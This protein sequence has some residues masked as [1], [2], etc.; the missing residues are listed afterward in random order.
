MKAIAFAASL[1]IAGSAIEPAHAQDGAAEDIKA[2]RAELDALRAKVDGLE[3]ALA[4]KQA[5]APVA[6]AEAKPEPKPAPTPAP[7]QI[8]MR[9]APQFQDKERGYAFKPRG[10]VQFDAGRVGNPGGV[11]PE[12]NLGTRLRARR[13]V[14]GADGSLPAGFAYKA[15]FN[16]SDGNLGYED[17]F[18]TWQPKDSAF[19]V[20][21]GHVFPLAGL[22]ANTSSRVTTMVER[23]QA[24]D[25]F[26]LP[27]R[28]GLS[29]GL[30]DP[31]DGYTLQA[32]VYQNTISSDFADNAWQASVRGTFSHKLGE[33]SR[34]HIGASFQHRRN[35]TDTK[36]ARYR[37]RPFTNITDVR[38]IDTSVLTAG[39]DDILG[40]E[41]AAILGPLHFAAEGH[42]LWVRDY[43][44][45]PDQGGLLYS[46]GPSF[47]TAYGEV[48]YFLTG[49][50]RGYK[51]GKW[52]RVK[53]AKPL[54]K[55]GWGAFQV[56]ARFERVDLTDRFGGGQFID[57]GVQDGY[58]VSASW[59]PI[60]HL[61]FLLQYSRIEVTGG[62][63]AALVVP[64]S[65]RP[66]EQRSFDTD[67]MVLRAQ[68][69]F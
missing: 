34:L 30:V 3:K 41:F 9:A 23:S 65:N 5:A 33:N 58:S 10:F 55:G 31:K 63:N 64:D 8:T 1:A 27:R 54:D 22:D 48:G 20:T 6:V 50:A 47:F 25:A 52:E 16:L 67:A 44:A 53:V 43:L 40:A 12:S 59:Y 35:R 13:I 39:G 61:R 60:D 49:E 21:L 68:F 26:T 37:T 42:K 18:L 45:P 14:F 56:A 51:A 32:G 69:D 2:L 11:F 15:E 17:V 29:A 28:V 57:G 36:R 19:L 7:V 4:E 38:F 24:S 66:P 46:T 62:P